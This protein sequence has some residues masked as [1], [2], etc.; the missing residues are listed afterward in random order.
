MVMGIAMALPKGKQPK[1]RPKKWRKLPP[2]HQLSEISSKTYK[3]STPHM[4]SV[5]FLWKLNHFQSN[6]C[7]P[8]GLLWPHGRVSDTRSGCPTWAE[9]RKKCQGQGGNARVELWR[10]VSNE[11]HGNRRRKTVHILVGGWTNPFEKYVRQNGFIFPN[12]RGET[13]DI[14]NHHRVF[15]GW[16]DESQV[17]YIAG[18]EFFEGGPIY[19]AEGRCMAWAY[20]LVK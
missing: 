10:R 2:G 20:L 17:H 15:E 16:G 12:F 9:S 13:K 3:T 1:H 6:Q 14:W 4:F 5:H 18:C 19:G 8:G 7:R 11:I